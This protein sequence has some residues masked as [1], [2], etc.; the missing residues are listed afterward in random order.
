M[1]VAV[2]ID[3]PNAVPGHFNVMREIQRL[4]ID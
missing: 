1:S 3:D 2:E 4:S